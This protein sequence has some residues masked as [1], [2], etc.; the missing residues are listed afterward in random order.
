MLCGALFWGLHGSSHLL[1]AMGLIIS[2]VEAT[3][4]PI[5]W[6]ARFPQPVALSPVVSLLLP[7][8]HGFTQ[9][10]VSG[11]NQRHLCHT[12]TVRKLQDLAP[13]Y[14]FRV[15]F[16]ALSIPHSGCD[17]LCLGLQ[18]YYIFCCLRTFACVSS[19][20]NHLSLLCEGNHYS[21]FGVNFDLFFYL[22]RGG[23]LP[24]LFA[25]QYT[26]FCLKHILLY[27]IDWCHLVPA[28]IFKA[29][30]GQ[31]LSTE[32]GDRYWVGDQ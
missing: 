9:F 1:S 18:M 3:E 2:C 29:R 15:Y 12:A 13:K 11:G 23:Y 26:H 5:N 10:L 25:M 27:C 30:C 20:W 32:H 22:T 14:P 19:A 6:L 17:E 31:N 8:C 4:T 7:I 24:P 21:E 28:S 16:F